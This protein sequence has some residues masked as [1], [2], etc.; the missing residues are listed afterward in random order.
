MRNSD[1]ETDEQGEGD[2]KG[3]RVKTVTL[4]SGEHESS[5][6]SWERKLDLIISFYYS[7]RQRR[8]AVTLDCK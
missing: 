6:R 1:T 5:S 8:C 4:N 3:H 7:L 2:M